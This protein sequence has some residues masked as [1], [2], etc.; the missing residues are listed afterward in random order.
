VESPIPILTKQD[1]F[2]SS[3]LTMNTG[4]EKEKVTELPISDEDEFL[5]L[6]PEYKVCS[7]IDV[8]M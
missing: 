6:V 4:V 3:A 7:S 8:P 1:Q 2:A 5:D